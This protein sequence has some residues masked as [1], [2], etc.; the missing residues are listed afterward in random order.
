MLSILGDAAAQN[1]QLLEGEA[2]RFAFLDLLL[3]VFQSQSLLVSIPIL[4]SFTRLLQPQDSPVAKIINQRA[5][6]FVQICTARMLKYE[7]LPADSQ[8]PAMLYLNEDFENLPELHAFLGNYRRYCVSII[9][10]IGQTVPRESLE[11]ILDESASM[12]QKVSETLGPSS[13][14][15]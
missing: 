3:S 11:Y 1:P 9:E 4:H 10:T 2:E 13:N 7:S 6:L 8:D 5:G 15:R 12:L 14:S